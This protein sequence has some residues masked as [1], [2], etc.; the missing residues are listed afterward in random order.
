MVK[1]SPYFDLN[2]GCYSK[3]QPPHAQILEPPFTPIWTALLIAKFDSLE[4]LAISSS[5]RKH[6]LLKILEYY[7]LH[8]EGLGPIK[9]N[10]V[11]EEV[12]A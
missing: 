2:L 12:L 4:G 9:S 1:S 8:I 10:E 3:T 5:E 7:Q 6:L 11:L